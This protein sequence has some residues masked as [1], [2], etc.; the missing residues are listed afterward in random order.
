MNLKK[1]Y[2]KKGQNFK[3]IYEMLQLKLFVFKICDI[4]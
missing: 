4:A 3:N 1:I 2:L